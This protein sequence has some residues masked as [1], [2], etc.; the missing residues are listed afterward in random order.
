MLFYAVAFCWSW[1]FWLAA[2]A[3]GSSIATPLGFALLLL[4]VLGPMVA[5]IGC[6][7]F[8]RNGESWRDYWRRVVD[9]RRIP[10]RWWPAAL[11]LAPALA[12]LALFFAAA[13]GD[14]AAV[15]LAR[16]NVAR[17]VEQPSAIPL[18]L[19][20]MLL[21][22]PLPEE[23]GWRGYALGRLQARHGPL[24]SALALGAIWAVWHLPLFYMK[25]MLHESHGAGSV[26]FWLFMVQVP[27]LSIVM[28]WL[29]NNTRRS[30]LGAILFHFSANLALTFC[31]VTALTNLCGTFLWI[32]LAAAAGWS[33]R[34][35]KG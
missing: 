9:P 13:L 6:A 20:S 17:H 2:A 5:G 26:W 33:G 8:T 12:A 27:C 16:A 28:T 3:L 31:D 15:G 23:L 19:V 22:G 21:L 10:A 32:A 29:F 14:G 18:F 30:T 35:A 4:G 11:L 34:R 24:T 1:S 25:G 7:W